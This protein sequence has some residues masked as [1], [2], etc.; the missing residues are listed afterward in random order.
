MWVGGS[1]GSTAGGMK[2]V[3]VAIISKMAHLGVYRTLR[4]HEVRVLYFGGRAVG[5]Q[6]QQSIIF[7][8][9]AALAIFLVASMAVTLAGLDLVT[10]VSAVVANLWNIGPGLGKVG[11]ESNYADVPMF[12]KGVLVLCQLLGR[13]E[14]MTVLVLFMP[15]F[16]E[17]IGAGRG[18]SSRRVVKRRDAPADVLPPPPGTV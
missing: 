18:Q 3:R 17:N 14:L 15:S 16:W 5:E 12:V 10:G 8:V 4:P 7:F 2:V 1:A 11:S 13:L 9:M 6:V